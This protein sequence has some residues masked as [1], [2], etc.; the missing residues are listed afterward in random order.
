MY[1][2]YANFSFYIQWGVVPLADN[3]TSDNYFYEMT[4]ITGLRHG[5]GTK[6]NINFVLSGD[7]MDTG[8]RKLRDQNGVKV[9]KL[10]CCYFPSTYIQSTCIRKIKFL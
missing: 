4:V 2:Y 8:V 1:V 9:S 5:A 6:S 10:T 7:T 3:V